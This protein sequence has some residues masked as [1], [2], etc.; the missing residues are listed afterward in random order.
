M[1]QHSIRTNGNAKP[2]RVGGYQYGPRVPG[3]VQPAERPAD[4]HPLI[5]ALLFILVICT[6]WAACVMFGANAPQRAFAPSSQQAAPAAIP[7]ALEIER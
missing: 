5:G 2:W 3:P 6:G 1:S 4:V 7:F